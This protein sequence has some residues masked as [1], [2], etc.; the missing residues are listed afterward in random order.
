MKR[1]QES[2]NVVPTKGQ[3]TS[4]AYRITCPVC[5]QPPHRQCLLVKE[6]DQQGHRRPGTYS[7]QAH[8]ERLREARTET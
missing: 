1:R 3:L 4:I 2:R 6:F 7:Y 5:K 8:P